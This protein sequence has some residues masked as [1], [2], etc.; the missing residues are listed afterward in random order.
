MVSSS[1]IRGTVTPSARDDMKQI[2]GMKQYE[3]NVSK[4]LEAANIEHQ[5]H[6]SLSMN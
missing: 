6:I 5:R 3:T 1:R 2:G 4:H